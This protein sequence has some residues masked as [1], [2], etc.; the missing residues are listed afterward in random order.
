MKILISDPISES[1]L[2]VI[3]EFGFKAIYLPTATDMEKKKASRDV[4]GW[5]IRSGTKINSDSF[6]FANNLRVIG[7]AGVGVDNID[8]IESTRKGVVVLNTPDSNTISAAEHTMG[9]ILS[10]SRNIHSGH[11]SL[12]NNLWDRNKFVGYE[13]KGKTIGIVGP[14]SYTHL[15]LPTK[16]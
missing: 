10:I 8:I 5:I 13:L 11:M 12:T 9:L 16:A 2:K 1:G 14:V 3:K 7:R 15:T 6:S 4:N